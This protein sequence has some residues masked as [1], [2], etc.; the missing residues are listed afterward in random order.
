MAT[1]GQPKMLDVWFE[2]LRSY[3]GQTRS[4]LE[5]IIVDDHGDPPA[6][7]PED[8]KLLLPCQLFRVLE[9]IHWNQ[10]GCRNLAAEHVRTPLVLF[11]DPDMVIQATMMERFLEAGRR[12]PIG[13]VIRFMLRHRNT[14]EMD[15]SSPNTWFMHVDDFFRVGGYDE[16]FSGAKGWSD[17]QLLDVMKANYK[18][19][20]RA[21]LYADF[22]SS[23]EIPDAAVTTLDRSTKAN[24]HKRLLK[25]K[26]ARMMGGWVKFARQQRSAPRLRFRWEK[27]P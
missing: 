9:E 5:L 13:H 21:D 26:Q 24:K 15:S 1:Y 20:H 8:V 22:Y 27:L 16:D 4:K 12:L 25:V 17:V 11:V 14:G 2:T 18:V 7:I 19:S 10:P 23:A 6:E 3:S